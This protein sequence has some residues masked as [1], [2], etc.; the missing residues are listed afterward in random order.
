MVLAYSM[1][2]SVIALYVARRVSFCLPHEVEVRA[3]RIL[4][5]ESDLSFVI[6]A[7]SLKL[8]AGSS[9]SP[10]ILGFL[11]VGMVM[12]LMVRF[13]VMS[14]SWVSDVKRVAVDLSGFSIRSFSF[15]QLKISCKYGWSLCSA[16]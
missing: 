13:R 4:I 9:V 11:T 3:L 15:V 8:K 2:G 6:L 12:L 5:V 16:M 1:T 10:R 7:C 14:C